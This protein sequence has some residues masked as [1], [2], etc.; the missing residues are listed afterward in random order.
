MGCQEQPKVEAT[1]VDGQGFQRIHRNAS[2]LWWSEDRSRRASCRA[3]L[4]PCSARRS[5]RALLRDEEVTSTSPA[6]CSTQPSPSICLSVQR[7]QE[8]LPSSSLPRSAPSPPPRR[9]WV[10]RARRVWRFPFPTPC[11]DG[12][13]RLPR[14]GDE[15]KVVD[16]TPFLCTRMR[17]PPRIP[18]PPGSLARRPSDR[19]RTP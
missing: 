14:E 10:R 17:R 7:S 15:T 13:R 11:A 8:T 2:S 3:R 1:P 5:R 19:I 4:V 18:A 6:A 12:T 9:S 16:G